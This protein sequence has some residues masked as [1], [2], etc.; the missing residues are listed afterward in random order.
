MLDPRHPASTPAAPSRRPLPPAADEV[1][2][3]RGL[4]EY[5]GNSV[6]TLAR[7]RK[8]GTGPA[9]IAVTPRAIRY[10]M[11]SVQAWLA[12]RTRTHTAA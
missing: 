11:A 6:E 3:T 1:L 9:W 4:A 10:S 8:E 12:E 2:D 7:W 5:L